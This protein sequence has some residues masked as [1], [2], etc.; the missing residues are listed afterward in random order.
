MQVDLSCCCSSAR[1]TFYSEEVKGL[2]KKQTFW[3]FSLCFSGFSWKWKLAHTSNVMSFVFIWTESCICSCFQ[4]TEN[5]AKTL[6]FTQFIALHSFYNEKVSKEYILWIWQI[7]NCFVLKL[8]WNWSRSVF[9][10]EQKSRNWT[11]WVSRNITL[12]FNSDNL[13][14]DDLQFKELTCNNINNYYLLIRYIFF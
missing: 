6:P 7:L 2:A 4:T 12:H 5:F 11:C 3:G 8:T 13:K 10:F 1:R 14:Y 9:I